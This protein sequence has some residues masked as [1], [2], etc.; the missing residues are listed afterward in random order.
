VPGVV[1]VYSGGALGWKNLGQPLAGTAGNPVLTG[2]GF[3]C[4]ARPS[5]RAR[6]RRGERARRSR[7]RLLVRA[8]A[9]ARRRAR[10]DPDVVLTGLASN[11]AGALALPGTWPAAC[12]P[13]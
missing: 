12:R 9:A 5:P 1:R 2:A 8:G 4:R 10:S 11:G 7:D 6:Q 3:C 13:R